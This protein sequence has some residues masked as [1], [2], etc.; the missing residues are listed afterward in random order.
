MFDDYEIIHKYT[1][2]QA[3]EDGVLR[4]LV[5]DGDGDRL[6][7][8]RGRCEAVVAEHDAREPRAGESR[9]PA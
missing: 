3:I 9:S 2:T 5:G 7:N 8:I 6:R 4:P 1:R